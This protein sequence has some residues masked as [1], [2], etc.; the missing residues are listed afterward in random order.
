MAQAGPTYTCPRPEPEV[1]AAHIRAMLA[2]FFKGDRR[3]GAA[4]TVNP[5]PR[6]LTP[7]REMMGACG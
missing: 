4:V 6:P 5:A 7:A 2:P 3:G 1:A